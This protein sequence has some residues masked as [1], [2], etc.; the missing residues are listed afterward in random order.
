MA[1]A[2]R[3]RQKHGDYDSIT[4]GDRFAAM[5]TAD[6]RA[7]SRDK[8]LSVLFGFHDAPPPLFDGPGNPQHSWKTEHWNCDFSRVEI[9]QQN[10]GYVKLDTFS[11][12]NLCEPTATAAMGF[13]ANADALIIDLRDNR[14]GRADMV[15][16]LSSY[17]FEGVMSLGDVR[18]RGGTIYEHRTLPNVS[19]KGLADKPVFVLTSSRTISAA[20]AFCYALKNLR[21][22]TIV[23]ERT[24]GA[25]HTVSF[26]S[27]DE[28]FTIIVPVGEAI[29]P[30]SKTN[31][32][33]VG[34]EPD[35]EVPAAD[36]LSTAQKLAAERLSLSSR[37][38]SSKG[39]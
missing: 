32:E 29:D 25:A 9:L 34:V 11:D 19:G 30:I 37:V 24:A 17:L 14:G 22:A 35:V 33:G 31:W 15:A 4:D 3:A 10:I 6:F 7:I 28:H 39:K 21:R 5:L 26:V 12:T 2:V 38:S 23:G 13:V 36:A 18:D 8:H 16:L 1:A 20:E 27:I